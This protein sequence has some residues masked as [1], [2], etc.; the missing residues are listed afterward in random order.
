MTS[1]SGTRVSTAEDGMYFDFH[2][3][4][5]SPGRTYEFRVLVADL[6]EDLILD[7]VSPKFRVS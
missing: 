4:A 2:M 3:D 5:L 7:G 6:G 1:N